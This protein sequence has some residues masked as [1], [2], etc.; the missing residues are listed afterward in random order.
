MLGLLWAA[1][2]LAEPIAGEAPPEQEVPGRNSPDVPPTVE[3]HVAG[4]G[5]RLAKSDMG[6]LT[7]S[8]YFAIRYL[9]QRALD[10]TY[11]DSTGTTATLDRRDDLQFQKAIIY[12]KGW[13]ADPAF[14]Y[15]T[16]VWTSNPSMGLGA[17]VVV[18]GNL[19]YRLHEALGV[20]AGIGALPTTRSTRGS[21]PRWLKQDSRTIADEYFR[22][23]Y[24]SGAWIW[25]SLVPK[26]LHYHAMI[27]NNLSQLGVDAGQLDKGMN[28]YSGAL[29]WSTAN[30]TA[31]AGMGDLEGHDELAA[32]LGAAFT[33]SRED[34]Q[35]QPGTNAP[36]NAQLRISDGRIIFADDVFAPGTTIDRATYVM[37][38]IEGELKYRGL[39]LESEVYV[40][41]LGN[42]DARGPLPIER[43]EDV[44]VQVQLSGMV[45]PKRLELY[46][47]YSK[48]VGD[49]G[50]P[51]DIGL[52]LNYYVFRNHV[53]R[54]NGEA[55]IV[56]RS[57]VGN[58]ASPPIVGADGV[59][60]LNNVGVF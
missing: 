11:T 25:G 59:S 47:T 41:R 35:S 9:N 37:A 8:L 21:F 14:R 24:T 46:G 42:F 12:F 7:F 56:D 18:A 58:L 36:D 32:S 49:Y 17:Q 52:G 3:D 16:Y 44:G 20:G 4:K 6:E 51:W 48:I 27:G 22:G 53:L 45:M 29:W 34:R 57:P 33:Y 50:D 23:S 2:A 5:L 13:L 39:A 1:T 43:L 26:H 30:V 15:L 60:F 38:S 31:Y 54:L 40:R 28:T 19:T 10:S 55:I